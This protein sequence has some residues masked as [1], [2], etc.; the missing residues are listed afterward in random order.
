MTRTEQMVEELTSPRV[1]QG[2]IIRTKDLLCSGS[3]LLDLA[4]TDRAA[5][6]FCKGKYYHFVGDSDA[7][8]TFMTLTA[9]AEASINKRF[10]KYRLIHDNVEDGV[11]MDLS[12]FFGR[13]A[14]ERI[15]PPRG[16][17]K[18]PKFS[19]TMEDFWFN[20]DD[21]MERGPCLYALD[22]LDAL[23]S[24][25]DRKKFKQQKS[26]RNRKTA[27]KA[28]GTYGTAKAKVN[29]A[30]MREVFNK[31]KAT[32]SILFIVSQARFAMNNPF[33]DKTF[34]G[35]T[36]LKFFCHAQIWFSPG[37]QLTRDVRGRQRQAGIVASVK[38]KKNRHTGRRSTVQVPIYWST[39]LDNTGGCVEFL[40]KEEH[41]KKKK[42]GLVAAK[43]LGVD[44][45]KEELIKYIEDE[46][47]EA[48]LH[49]LVEDVWDEIR[50]GCVPERK[51][52]YHRD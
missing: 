45:R 1:Q 37:G 49:A 9:F 52:K 35:G 24:R 18:D 25:A 29:A 5:G 33:D 26:R 12:K 31:L 8:K 50:L 36:A 17:R 14:Y 6:G 19:E 20:L 34:S 11:L 30:H 2:P 22:S 3:T 39:G 43:E 41:W 40:L 46:N 7:G 13:A 4:L 32:G 51:N 10:R 38:V 47:R 21:A 28:A 23:S 27:D 42:G 44:L 48:E 15:E 16:T